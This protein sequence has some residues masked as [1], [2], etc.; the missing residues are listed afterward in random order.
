[1]LRITRVES[2][3]GMPT[4]RFEGKLQGVWV[5]EMRAAYEALRTELAPVGLDLSAVT[6]IDAPGVELL[7]NLIRQGAKV[8]ALSGFVAEVLDVRHR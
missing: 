7:E 2:F 8:T 1:M 5:D 3:E 6:F 4:L